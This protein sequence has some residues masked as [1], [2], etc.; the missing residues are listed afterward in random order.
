MA[1]L[2]KKTKEQADAI[3]N[4]IIEIL[5]SGESFIVEAGAGSGKTYSLLR[6]IDWLEQN[7]CDEYRSKKKKIACITFTNAAVNVILERLSPDSSII[8]STIHSFAWELISS[9]QQTIIQYVKELNLM[10]KDCTIEQVKNVVYSLGAKYLE[11]GTLYLF[12]KDV[13]E[14]FA[15]FLDNDKFRR[16]LSIK[17]PIIL[18]DEYQDSFKIIT[19][20]FVEHFIEGSQSMQFGF[21]GDSWQTIYASNGACGKIESK[22]LVK[23]QKKLNFRSNIAIVNTLNAIRADLQQEAVDQKSDGQ[24]IA[25]TTHD[26]HGVR[27]TG[28][29]K[30]ELQQ[31][32]LVNYITTLKKK[33]E[34]K[35]NGKVKTLMITHKMLAIQQHYPKVLDLLGD[36]FKEQSNEYIL[37]FKNIIEPIYNALSNNNIN[38][39]CDVLKTRRMPIE[40][41]LQK[42]SWRKLYKTLKKARTNKIIDV[43]EVCFEFSKIIPIPS[44]IAESYNGFLLNNNFVYNNVSLMELYNIDYSEM[45][46]AIAFVSPES[47]YST[48][49]GVKGEE[50]E[51][52]LFV[53]SR[54]WN[55]YKFDEQVYLN[56]ENLTEKEYDVYIRNR[57]LFYVCC[58]RSIKKLALFVTVPVNEDFQNYLEKIIGEKNIYTYNLF[59]NQ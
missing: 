27:Q 44:A 15:K 22:N 21:F 25:I 54:G 16:L 30:S 4:H 33:L 45:I 5:K 43:L 26:Y 24:V 29:Y 7:K 57:N 20:K 14:L 11:N 19:D 59:I 58:S 56:P 46:N 51:N 37:F 1:I 2:D 55:N 10:P 47:D 31:N 18:I 8:P 53:I 3:D 40:N 35:W 6:V 38:E 34:E 50:Y 23:I 39:L 32:D 49:H 52:V 13:I 28:Y 41:K 12:H 48:E 17:Y 36:S 9:Y 42:N